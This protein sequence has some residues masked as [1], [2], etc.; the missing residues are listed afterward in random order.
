MAST[1]KYNW[2][3]LERNYQQERQVLENKIKYQPAPQHPL[4][5][6]I[7]TSAAAASSLINGNKPKSVTTP[8]ISVSSPLDPLS[9]PSSAPTPDSD[10]PLSAAAASSA[11]STSPAASIDDPLQSSLYNDPLRRGMSIIATTNPLGKKLQLTAQLNRASSSRKGKN[12]FLNW[13]A[14]KAIYLK[15]FT[16]EKNIPVISV[17]YSIVSFDTSTH[18]FFRKLWKTTMRKFIHWKKS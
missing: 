3:P 1:F 18:F 8:V 7:S 17:C 10:D 16:T 9:V 11:I 14:K 6:K 12:T 15:K 5:P 2:S 4:V 13:S